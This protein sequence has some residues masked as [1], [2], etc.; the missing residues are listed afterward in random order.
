MTL[1]IRIALPNVD[2]ASTVCLV[3]SWTEHVQMDVQISFKAPCAK[4]KYRNWDK[5]VRSFVLDKLQII[6][7]FDSYFRRSVNTE[8]CIYT[9]R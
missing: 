6:V 2:I 1:N 7:I 9:Q 3:T 8:N 4:V 5:V